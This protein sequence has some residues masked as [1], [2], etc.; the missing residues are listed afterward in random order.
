MGSVTP[1]RRALLARVHIAVKDLALAPESYQ[2]ILRRVA[3]VE[4]AANA[5]N[6]QLE[7]VLKD[8]ARLGWKPHKKRPAS[9]KPHVRLIYALWRD[10]RPLLRD[11]SD[12][13]LRAFVE[14][15]TGV[16]DPEWLDGKDA[17]KVVEGLK[18]WRLRLDVA[19]DAAQAAAQ[20]AA[21]GLSP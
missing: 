19:A 5:S 16:S 3:G 2:C 18:A 7:A 8:F 15:Q 4:S 13:A 1:V 17:A 21:L 6:A 9:G 20:A 14:R 11:G 10:M 12:G